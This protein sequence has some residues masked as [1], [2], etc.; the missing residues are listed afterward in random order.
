MLNIHLRNQFPPGKP[1]FVLLLAGSFLFSCKPAEREHT[2]IEK[3]GISKVIDLR[4]DSLLNSL[5][6][7]GSVL[8]YDPNEKMYYSND[9]EWAETGHLP[10]STFK[11]PNSIIALETGRVKDEKTM[12]P[13]D[14]KRRR[15]NI[16]EKD[17]TFREAFQLS[18]VPCYQEI[19]RKTGAETMRKYLDL[20]RY[21]DMIVDSAS[22]DVF[23][24][25]G[26]SKISQFQQVDFLNRF[27]NSELPVSDSTVSIMKRIL[28][29]EKNESWTISAK[30]GWSVRNGNN[31]GWYVGYL[32]KGS[33]VY[34]F[35]SNVDP[36]EEFNLDMFYRIRIDLTMQAL[37]ILGLIDQ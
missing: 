7:D 34:F 30:T 15:M 6:L 37:R 27:Y 5:D 21:G 24:L 19:A 20:F 25:E 18:C 31:N 33:R 1:A 4:I 26:D 35:A 28:V 22:I 12:F 8:V 17:L 2:G 10:A 11:I 16:W 9:F 13:W 36:N 29:K 14:G 23:W 32:E 3:S